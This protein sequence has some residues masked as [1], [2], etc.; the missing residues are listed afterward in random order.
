MA[1]R[2]LSSFLHSSILAH[3]SFERSLAF[4]LAN[5]LA[6]PTMLPTQLFEI[7]HGVLASD[8][9]VRC[10]ALADLEACKDR[11]R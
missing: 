7:F 4:V 5:R 10:G 2:L 11:V 6:T 3:E 8:D 9:N 1:E